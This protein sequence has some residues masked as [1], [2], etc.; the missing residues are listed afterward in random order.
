MKKRGRLPLNWD[1]IAKASQVGRRW[2]DEDTGVRVDALELLGDRWDVARWNHTRLA[3]SVATFEWFTRM[4]ADPEQLPPLHPN[5]HDDDYEIWGEAERRALLDLRR[6]WDQQQRWRPYLKP[7]RKTVVSNDELLKYYEK[8]PER[9]KRQSSK[10][11]TQLQ[12][13][14]PKMFSSISHDRLR[15]QLASALKQ[16]RKQLAS[17][18]KDFGRMGSVK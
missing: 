4:K 15:K 1:V 6:Q 3:L 5:C 14:Y 8:L 2:F 18:L 7:G 11:A 10:A 9:H 16:R 13:T 12:E 17:A